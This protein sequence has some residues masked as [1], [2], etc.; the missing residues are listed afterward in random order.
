MYNDFETLNYTF[1]LT[2]KLYLHCGISYSAFWL[3]TKNAFSQKLHIF[4]VL[5]N[6][7]TLNEYII[8]D[9]YNN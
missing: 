9:K 1:R 2:R 8:M 4:C 3:F 7:K 6:I 5:G